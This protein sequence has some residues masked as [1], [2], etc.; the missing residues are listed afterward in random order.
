MKKS[1]SS[2]VELYRKVHLNSLRFRASRVLVARA[3]GVGV[4]IGRKILTQEASISYLSR[5]ERIPSMLSEN[6]KMTMCTHAQVPLM[7][8]TTKLVTK[9]LTIAKDW[10]QL[11][12]LLK[13]EK[14]HL[15]TSKTF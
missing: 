4:V 8:L 3:A 1:K 5:M 6:N 2:R 9:T 10:L 15:D 12:N 7:T 13:K 11:P 14:E